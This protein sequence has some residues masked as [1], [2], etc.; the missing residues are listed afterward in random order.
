[1]RWDEEE[2]SI[3]PSTLSMRTLLFAWLGSHKFY[4]GYNSLGVIYFLVLMMGI[5]LTI[6]V[7][8][9]IPITVFGRSFSLN[10]GLIILLAPFVVSI[11]EFILLRRYSETEI[12]NSYQRTPDNQTIVFVTQ[13]LMLFVL[14]IP[15]LIRVLS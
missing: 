7:P 11:I 4:V 2:S 15:L 12:Q 14:L 5:V 9:R 10:L 3:N 8:V 6:Y 1:M 13:F